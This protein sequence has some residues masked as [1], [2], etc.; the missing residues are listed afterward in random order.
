MKKILFIFFISIFFFLKTNQVHA[1]NNTAFIDL[2]I[3]LKKTIIGKLLLNDLEVINN[4]NIEELK[5]K[6]KE[7]KNDEEEIKKKQKLN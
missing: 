3:V 2:D 6:E 4:K 5:N 1:N 7:L